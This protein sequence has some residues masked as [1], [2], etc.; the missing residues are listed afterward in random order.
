M[1]NNRNPFR[2][3][4]RHVRAPIQHADLVIPQVIPTKMMSSIPSPDPELTPILTHDINTNDKAPVDPSLH[5]SSEPIPPA[6]DDNHP[7]STIA[8][9]A[10]QPRGQG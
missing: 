10:I 9:K 4:S 2:P 7:K 3:I 6:V 8:P 5:M 1:T